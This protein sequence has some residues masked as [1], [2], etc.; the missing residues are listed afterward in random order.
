MSKWPETTILI[1]SAACKHSKGVFLIWSLWLDGNF[2]FLSETVSGLGKGHQFPRRGGDGSIMKNSL[3]PQKYYWT[4][5]DT[6]YHCSLLV[7]WRGIQVLNLCYKFFNVIFISYSI[8]QTLIAMLCKVLLPTLPQR[9][10]IASTVESITVPPPKRKR[11]AKKAKHC[12]RS[13]SLVK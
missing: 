3:H 13:N 6:I 1:A 11:E 5:F 4:P 9:Y 7:F 8:T 2:K 10:M 12:R